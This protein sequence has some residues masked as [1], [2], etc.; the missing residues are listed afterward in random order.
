[1]KRRSHRLAISDRTCLWIFI[2]SL[3][4]FVLVAALM[5][6]IARIFLRAIPWIGLVTIGAEMAIVAIFMATATG[7]LRYINSS[8]DEP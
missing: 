6:S 1:M 3:L 8:P 5:P 2:L 7:V 4:S